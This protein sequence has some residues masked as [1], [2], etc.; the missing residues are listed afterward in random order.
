LTLRSG[1]PLR[2]NSDR[3][4]VSIRKALTGRAALGNLFASPDSTP[5]RQTAPH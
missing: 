2:E 5:S 3:T 4:L 1:S